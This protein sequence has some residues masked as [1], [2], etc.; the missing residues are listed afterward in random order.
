MVNV[1]IYVINN[2]V[3]EKV[4]ISVIFPNQKNFV[5]KPKHKLGQE[6]DP[7]IL[8]VQMMTHMDFQDVE[9]NNLSNV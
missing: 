8:G 9:I 3:Q 4:Q 7:V 2:N 1:V 5:L 6:Q